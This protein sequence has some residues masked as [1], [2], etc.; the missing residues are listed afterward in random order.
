MA[1]VF[2]TYACDGGGKLEEHTFEIMQDRA[3]GPPRYCPACG[4]IVSQATPRPARIAIGG[5]PIIKATDMT[6]RALEAQGEAAYRRTGN[7]NMKITNMRDHLREGDVAAMPMPVNSVTR[8]MQDAGDKGIG[9][10]WG[11]GGSMIAPATSQPTA[12]NYNGW[13]GPGHPA[14]SA[15][16]GA[17]GQTHTVTRAQAA[18]QGRLNKDAK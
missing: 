4:C 7:P 15:I 14:L 16:Q 1:Y 8:F 18:A 6:Y 9:Y 2:R 10:G 5:K 12:I 13:T 11:G 17:A 3:E